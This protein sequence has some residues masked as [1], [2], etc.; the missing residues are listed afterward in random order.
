[1]TLYWI[2]T[3]CALGV[4]VRFWIRHRRATAEYNALK[5]GGK[6]WLTTLADA[7]KE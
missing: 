1:M 5:P 6:Q 4:L 2:S 3:G 7:Q